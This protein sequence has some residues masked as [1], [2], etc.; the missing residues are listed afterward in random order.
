MRLQ[1]AG[2]MTSDE[3]PMNTS[4]TIDPTA[5]R[6]TE[7]RQA[8]VVLNLHEPLGIALYLYSVPR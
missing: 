6:L 1:A 4:K 3:L 8:C 7:V 5:F 2:V